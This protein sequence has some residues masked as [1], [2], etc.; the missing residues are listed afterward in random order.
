MSFV[1]RLKGGLDRTLDALMILLLSAI[2]VLV[3]LQIF[4]RYFALFPTPW[5]EEMSRFL[6]VYLTFLGSALLLKEKGHITVD[7]VV[8]HLPRR[9]QLGVYVLVQLLLLLFLW[10]FTGGMLELTLGSVDV[11][12]ASMTWFSM[13]YLYG[14]V[15]LGGVL[16]FVYALIEMGKGLVRLVRPG[17]EERA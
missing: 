10:I 14:G 6:F 12:A 1:R 11:R 2:V 3:L 17:E 9:L 7:V 13:A 5:T 8:E 15:W 16:M 4:Q